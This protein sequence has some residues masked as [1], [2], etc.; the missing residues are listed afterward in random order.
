MRLSPEELQRNIAVSRAERLN[1]G[2]GDAIVASAQDAWRSGL[3]A[4]I[5]RGLDSAFDTTAKISPAEANEKYGLAG[6]TAEIAPDEELTIADA[7]ARS[8]D[9][10]DIKLRDLITETVNE[11]APIMG[12]VTQFIAGMGASMFDPAMMAA[13]IAGTGIIS[14]AGQTIANS[15]RAL[16]AISKV[17]TGAAKGIVSAYAESSTRSMMAVVA[18]EGLENFAGSV[19]E[20][21]VA[22]V[23]DIGQERLAR[24]ITVGERLQNV[25]AG[26]IFGAGLGV[27]MSKDGRAA[28]ARS[29]GRM[30]G[31]DAGPLMKTMHDVKV[32]EERMGLEASGFEAK[33]YDLETFGNRPEYGEPDVEFEP[34]TPQKLFIPVSKEGQYHSVSNRGSGLTMTGSKVHAFNKGDVVIEVD[35]STLNL[36]T[37]ESL[38]DTKGRP[39]KT[40]SQV[41]DGLVEDF[42]T[43]ADS[44]KVGKILALLDDA[45]ADIDGIQLNRNQARKLIKEKMQGRDID[46]MV[47]L[48]D[49]IS[50]RHGLDYDPSVKLEGLMEELGFDGYVFTGKNAQGNGAYN[51]V[52]VREKVAANPKKMNKVDRRN[53]PIEGEG[54]KILRKHREQEMFK[55][56]AE[57]LRKEA[58]TLKADIKDPQ[59]AGIPKETVD[60]KAPKT[61]EGEAF[62]GTVEKKEAFQAVKAK[63]ESEINRV[64]EANKTKA[65][66]SEGKSVVEE[67]VDGEILSDKNIMDLIEQ[68]KTKEEIV[69][70]QTKATLDYLNCRLG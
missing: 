6:T 17:S 51:G 46:E 11:D 26:T 56:H 67:E 32:A 70:L 62:I 33:M 31:D 61:A 23:V 12:K 21:G 24:K 59:V 49:S 29:W 58:K 57:W 27:P 30:F 1:V 37:R 64:Q 54:D 55:Q 16:N 38:Y 7:E 8:K 39:T 35:P 63:Y 52:Y 28:I 48:I 20:E 18:R 50:S 2:I 34:H 40:F 9:Y 66:T 43:V 44:A 36:V 22:S 13:N 42:I 68:G 47:D 41:M 65:A 5:S 3:S 14:K 19:I 4:T 10:Q 25:V 69:E 60:E 53:R 45:D 15:G